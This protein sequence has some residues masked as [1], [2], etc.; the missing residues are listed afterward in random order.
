MHVA[1]VTGMTARYYYENYADSTITAGLSVS[2]SG[3]SLAGSV[4]VTNS[5]STNATTAEGAGLHQFIDSNFLY[6]D[7]LVSAGLCGN[8]YVVMPYDAIGDVFQGNQSQENP[9]GSCK[10]DPNLGTATINSRGGTYGT[11]EET[12]ENYSGIASFLG[13]SFGGSTGYSTTIDINW[14][15][16]GSVNTYVCGNDGPANSASILYNNPS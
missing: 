11:H 7:F 15:D 1:N 3:F 6:G 8:F 5:I 4:S 16:N 14:H 13:F 10:N 12:A 2:N 9:W